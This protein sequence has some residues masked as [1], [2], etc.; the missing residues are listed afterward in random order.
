MASDRKPTPPTREAPSHRG[1]FFSEVVE[2]PV[3]ARAR[4]EA[5]HHRRVEGLE[6]AREAI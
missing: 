6:V 3:E 4:L 1:S 2:A 5:T